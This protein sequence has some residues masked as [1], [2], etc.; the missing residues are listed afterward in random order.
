MI[1]DA[2]AGDR[3]AF[4]RTFDVC[5]IG[6]GPAGIT[7]ARRLAAAGADVA[8]MEAGGLDI[9][10]ESQDVYVGRNV[11]RDYFELD[12]ARLRYFGGSSNHWGGMCRGLDSYDFEPHA[13]HPLSGWP[14]GK[15]DLDPYRTEVRDILDLS[16]PAARRRNGPPRPEP[17]RDGPEP[18]D[19]PDVAFEQ[20]I[21]RLRQVSFRFSPPVRFGEKYRAEIEAAPGILLVLNANLVDIRLDEAPE[22]GTSPSTGLRRWRGRS[23]APTTRPTRASR[24]GR[25]STA[26]APAGWRIP[27]CCSPSAASGRRGS[28]TART[29]SD[30]SSA[31]IRASPG[32]T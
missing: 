6:A 17:E 1:A 23:S 5:V 13:W 10:A 16:A 2:A 20:T 25:G 24:C 32:P 31:S 9:T 14:I 7:L 8:L 4:Q 22:T 26:C 28:A 15:A 29:W 30:G 12:T 21:P 11:G 27:G 19:F 3:T 18:A